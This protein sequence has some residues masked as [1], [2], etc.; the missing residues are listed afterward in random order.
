VGVSNISG[1]DELWI[2]RRFARLSANRQI[3]VAPMIPVASAL[4]S[5]RSKLRVDTKY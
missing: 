2:Q 3:K 4:K 5:R 1:G